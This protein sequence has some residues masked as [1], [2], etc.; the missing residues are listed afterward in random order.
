MV[1]VL[2]I[3]VVWVQDRRKYVDFVNHVAVDSEG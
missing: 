1:G 2:G 3:E